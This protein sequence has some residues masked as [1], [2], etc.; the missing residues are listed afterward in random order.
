[1]F[2]RSV[3]RGLGAAAVALMRADPARRATLGENARAWVQANATWERVAQSIVDEVAARLSL[4][5]R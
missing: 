1:M 5:E 3:S 2:G 4:T